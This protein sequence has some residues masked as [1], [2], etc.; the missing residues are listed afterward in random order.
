LKIALPTPELQ[1]INYTLK[2]YQTLADRANAATE[3]ARIAYEA[4]TL[5]AQAYGVQL[6]AAADANNA[7]NEAMAAQPGQTDQSILAMAALTGKL[8]NWN[9]EIKYANEMA[10]GWNSGMKLNEVTML[11][12]RD[13]AQA[14]GD[15]LAYL[16]SVKETLP[17]ADQQI[18]QATAARD[19]WAVHPH[20]GR[21]TPRT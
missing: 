6:L 11:G 14:T 12:L 4:G 5:S 9:R 10:A 21:A 17:N 1:T 19:A 3:A 13:A 2:D 8:D 18:A 7:L 16:Q 20:N 15:K